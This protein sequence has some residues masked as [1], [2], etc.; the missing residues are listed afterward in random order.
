MAS[1]T[2]RHTAEHY[3]WGERCDGWHLVRDRDL[4]VIEESMP[5][6]SAEV[7]HHHAK[8]QQFFFVLSGTATM[9]IDGEVHQLSQGSGVRV[10]PD[11]RHQIRNESREPMQFLVISQPPSHGDRINE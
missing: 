7:R 1:V 5:P 9:E 3:T 6:N 4:S 2:N 8:A 10:L 11:I